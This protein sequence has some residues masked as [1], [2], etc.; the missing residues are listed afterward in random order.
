[1][2]Q[3]C[4]A[5]TNGGH[6]LCSRVCA[7]ACSID[8]NEME[9]KFPYCLMYGRI[10]KKTNH[11]VHS[12]VNLAFREKCQAFFCSIHMPNPRSLPRLSPLPFA[13]RNYLKNENEFCRV[14]F[15]QFT[16]LKRTEPGSVPRSQQLFQFKKLLLSPICTISLRTIAVFPTFYAENYMI[17][18]DYSRTVFLFFMRDRAKGTLL[19]LR[20][21]CDR[22]H[23]S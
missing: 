18:P 9:L 19:A 13:G 22:M 3:L 4:I 16:R 7:R 11:G 20:T 23:H 14:R 12:M 1:M 5:S 17:I 8:R 21:G 15:V 2:L 6:Y 10:T